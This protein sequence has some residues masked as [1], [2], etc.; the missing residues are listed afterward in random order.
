MEILETFKKA[1][2]L[3]YSSYVTDDL[4]LTEDD[5]TSDTETDETEFII[6]TL[7]DLAEGNIY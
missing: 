2:K 1:I 4:H 7:Y 3:F 6:P 5:A